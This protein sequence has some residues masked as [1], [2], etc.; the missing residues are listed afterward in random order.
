MRS[1]LSRQGPPASLQA[2]RT[3]FLFVTLPDGSARSRSSWTD[4]RSRRREKREKMAGW[5]IQ[6]VLISALFAISLCYSVSRRG[7]WL[8]RPTMFAICD[9]LEPQIL[10]LSLRLSLRIL[11]TH[12]LLH[13]CSH[14]CPVSWVKGVPCARLSSRAISHLIRFTMISDRT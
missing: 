4:R 7:R 11:K 1:A 2:A 13:C 3:L 9:P 8:R 12:T 10:R 6:F 14:A 5:V